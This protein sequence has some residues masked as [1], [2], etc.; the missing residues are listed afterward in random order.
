MKNPFTLLKQTFN[1]F[2]TIKKQKQV[3]AKQANTK[4]ETARSSS[5]GGSPIPNV[6]N[7]KKQMTL[8]EINTIRNRGRAFINRVNKRRAKNKVARRSRRINRMRAH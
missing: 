6:G 8:N 4:V 5:G 3:L 1:D 7:D 2:F